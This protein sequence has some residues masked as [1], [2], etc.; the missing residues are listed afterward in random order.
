MLIEK[1]ITQ[2]KQSIEYLSEKLNNMFPLM[3]PIK[4]KPLMTTEQYNAIFPIVA[5]MLYQELAFASYDTTLVHFEED[6]NMEY[7][8]TIGIELNGF[9]IAE[10][11][12][13]KAHVFVFTYEG[14]WLYNNEPM[15]TPIHILEFINRWVCNSYECLI[16]NKS[17]TKEKIDMDNIERLQ[18]EIGG[19]ELPHEELLVYLEEEGIEGYTQYNASSKANKKAIYQSALSVLNSIANQPHAMKNYKHDDMTVESFAKYL[20]SRID[21]LEKKIRQ[22]PNEDA[23]PTNFFNLFN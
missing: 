1:L 10:H 12:T 5:H 17:L 13:A 14:I 11:K 15:D 18:M 6:E 19:I 4:Q 21:Q 9:Y 3:K 2:P 20:Q 16:Y 8:S 7:F 22:M 23:T